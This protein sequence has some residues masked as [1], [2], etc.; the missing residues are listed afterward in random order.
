[1]LKQSLLFV[2][3]KPVVT[4]VLLLIFILFGTVEFVG[5][6]M[7]WSAYTAKTETINAIGYQLLLAAN[8]NNNPI[9]Q[10]TQIIIY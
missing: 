9:E 7:G 2:L 1:M 3:R 5:L 8:D 10:S 4:A 6:T